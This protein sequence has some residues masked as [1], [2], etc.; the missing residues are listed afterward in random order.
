LINNL[1]SKFAKNP[2]L[3]IYGDNYSN[4]NL[5]EF[6]NYH[7]SLQSHF[8]I[9][10]C[11]LDDVSQSGVAELGTNGK[12]I[13]FIEKP[14]EKQNSNSWVNAGIY[15]IEPVVLDEIKSANDFGK[16]VIPKLIEENFSIYGYKMK[17]KL[18][19]IDTPRLLKEM[20]QIK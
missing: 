1:K 7:K 18:I 12:I 4:I 17:N 8:T 15:I 11:K 14:K 6:S 20:N 16:E 10:L 2:F 13:R 19:P 3:V 9:A 5:H